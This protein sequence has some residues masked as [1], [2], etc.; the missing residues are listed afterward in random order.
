LSI[1]FYK[2]VDKMHTSQYNAAEVIKVSF[3]NKLKEARLALNL[4]QQ[5]IADQMG[6]TKTTYCGYE[7][8]RRQPD[9]EK[10]KQLAAILEVSGDDLLETNYREDNY[11]SLSEKEVIKKYRALDEHGIE[12]VNAVLDVEYKRCSE[13]SA[14]QLRAARGGGLNPEPLPIEYDGDCDTS[15]LKS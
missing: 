3:A 11:L 5:Q 9:V 12:V 6:I 8:G 15:D 2:K 4:T 10:I 7:N 1:V 13:R 14:P